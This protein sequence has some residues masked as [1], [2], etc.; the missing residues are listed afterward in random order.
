MQARPFD[1]QRGAGGGSA[2]A[3]GL[4]FPPVVLV[5]ELALLVLQRPLP[6]LGTALSTKVPDL[7]TDL[8]CCCIGAATPQCTVPAGCGYR[9]DALLGLD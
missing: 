9:A 2:A 7:G 1:S 8:G 5:R 4:R 3:L 6:D